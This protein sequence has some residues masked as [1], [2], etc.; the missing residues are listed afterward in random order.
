MLNIIGDHFIYIPLVSVA[1]FMAVVGYV[2]V[3]EGRHPHH[4]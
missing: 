2:T 3:A 1:F 4:P